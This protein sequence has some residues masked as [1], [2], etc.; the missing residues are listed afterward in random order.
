MKT[1]STHRSAFS[2]ITAIFVILL[3][4]TVAAFILSLAGKIVEETTA[5]YRK[6]QAILYAKSYTEFAIMSA[7]AR[8][9]IKTI[10]ANVGGSATEVKAGQ[11][12]RVSV[13]L[14]YIGNELS[15]TTLGNAITN[16]ASRGAVVLIDTYVS[17][18]NPGHPHAIAGDAWDNE[19]PGISYH[20]RTLQRL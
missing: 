7:T 1:I 2:M 10:T 16:V 20:R 8:D 18:R 12:Y 6:E 11:G 3:L 4:A 13:S 5:Q 19:H 14:Q 15:C 9:C 17:Y